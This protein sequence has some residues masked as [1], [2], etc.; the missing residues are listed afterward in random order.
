MYVKVCLPY[1][2]A[3]FVSDESLPDTKNMFYPFQEDIR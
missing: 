2:T 3:N 1:N